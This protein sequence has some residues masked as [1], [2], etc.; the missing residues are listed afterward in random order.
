MS[1]EIRDSKSRGFL[2]KVNTRMESIWKKTG[3]IYTQRILSFPLDD[4]L[5]SIHHEKYIRSPARIGY[6]T[7]PPHFTDPHSDQGNHRIF[8]RKPRDP[9]IC[10]R[11]SDGYVRL[12]SERHRSETLGTGS[13][14][15]I[16][17]WTW[18]GPG[19]C[20][21]IRRN[22]RLLIMSISRLQ[23]DHEFSRP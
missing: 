19:V 11:F 14:S 16:C 3:K 10:S 8:L 7:R 1:E 9:G 2:E 17:I 18:E 4:N 12:G 13:H 23:W 6:S 21:D 20:R 5:T 22:D 15:I